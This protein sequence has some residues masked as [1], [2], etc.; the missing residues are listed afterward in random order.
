GARLFGRVVPS[1]RDRVFVHT[2]RVPLGVVAAITPWNF[3]IAIPA[4]KACPAMIAGN[5]VVL[6]PSE[7]APLCAVRLAEVLHEAGLPAGVLNL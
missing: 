3:P 1:E 4:W 7:L 5:A 2:L 6:K